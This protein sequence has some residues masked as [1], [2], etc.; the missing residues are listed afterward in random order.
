MRKLRLILIFGITKT[1]FLSSFWTVNAATVLDFEREGNAVQAFSAANIDLIDVVGLPASKMIVKGDYIVRVSSGLTFRIPASEVNV[2]LE[3]KDLGKISSLRFK[4][5]RLNLNEVDS[6]A[7]A[8]YPSLGL[9]L[10]DYLIW[11]DELKNDKAR[12]L[13]SQ[14]LVS[15][16]PAIALI[17]LKSFH[18]TE[19]AVA[20]FAF[21]WDEKSTK[22][23][24]TSESGNTVKGLDYNIPEILASVQSKEELAAPTV[25]SLEI[26]SSVLETKVKEPAEVAPVKIAEEA[27]EESTNWL[28][29]L[30]GCLVVLG[31]LVV[32]ARRKK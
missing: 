18:P 14:S 10:D 31:G 25:E 12:G 21:Q 20:M 26:L 4:T 15:N 1:V 2:T 5:R 22:R 16:Y 29:W 19:P 8:V 23:R 30:I 24:G 27:P 32:V 9:P 3:P 28:L 11:F 13:H 7:Q 17:F 6:I